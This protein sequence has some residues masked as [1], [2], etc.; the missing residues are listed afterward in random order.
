[1]PAA[2][3]QPTTSARHRYAPYGGAE[4]PGARAAPPE[5]YT[6]NDYSS[7]GDRRHIRFSDD[8]PRVYT[9]GV[10]CGSGPLYD[11]IR[12]H[13]M[14]LTVVA[15]VAAATVMESMGHE[16]DHPPLAI[17]CAAVAVIVMALDMIIAN[18]Q[19]RH[20]ATVVRGRAA[21][22]TYGYQYIFKWVALLLVTGFA[23]LGALRGKVG[24]VLCTGCVMAAMDVVLMTVV[25]NPRGPPMFDAREAGV[26]MRTLRV[27][28]YGV[29]VVVRMALSLLVFLI[30]IVA[31]GKTVEELTG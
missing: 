21:I 8:P 12:W 26:C 2:R 10:P 9:G 5:E 1:M 23:S 3:Q 28:W 31:I 22:V 16:V 13:T 30:H 27:V 18:R 25:W 20:L 17:G 14:V 7:N 19:A 6:S 15:T 11:R 24:G 29:H 4:R